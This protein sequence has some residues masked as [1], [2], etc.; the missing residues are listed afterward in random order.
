M[1]RVLEMSQ[2]LFGSV[3]VENARHAP[4]AERVSGEHHLATPVAVE[5]GD[6][7]AEQLTTVRDVMRYLERQRTVTPRTEGRLRVIR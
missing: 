6:D 4:G 2:Y 7:I 1:Q 3:E 5:I